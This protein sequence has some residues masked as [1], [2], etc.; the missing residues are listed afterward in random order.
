MI[1]NFV[2]VKRDFRNRDKSTYHISMPTIDTVQ[3]A[4]IYQGEIL[5]MKEEMRALFDPVVDQILVLIS[6]QLLAI[7]GEG[8]RTSLVLL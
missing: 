6:T 7:S 4:G 5:V 2:P 8:H 1:K 3:E